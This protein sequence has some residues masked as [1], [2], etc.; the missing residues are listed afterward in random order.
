MFPIKT[1]VATRYM[2]LVTWS[3]VAVN[4][5]AFLYQISLPPP[6]RE[7]FLQHFALIPAR[8][9]YPGWAEAQGIDSG[10]FL[11]FVT[12]IFLHGGWVHLLGNMW[13]LLIFGPAIEDRLGHGR[14]FVFY[15]LCG[16]GASAAHA[17]VNATSTIP[18]LGASGAIAGIMGAYMRLFPLSRMLVVVPVFIVPFFFEMHAAVFVGI[19]FIM[20]LLGGLGGLLAGTAGLTGGIAWWAHIGGFA[21]GWLIIDLIRHG[22]D[23]YRPFQRDEGVHGFLPNGRRTGKGPWQ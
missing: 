13:M 23:T 19:W 21:V 7:H 11:P 4:V 12:N 14:Y 10:L 17:W 2:P 9:F 6:V 15:M 5:L 22:P 16:V 1:T 20:Q 3:L 8:F 18:A